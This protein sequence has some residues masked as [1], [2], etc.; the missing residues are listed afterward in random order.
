MPLF[1]KQRNE[2][3]VEWMDREDC[4]VEL[5]NNTYSQFSKINKLLSGWNKIYRSHIRPVIQRSPEKHVTILDIG[6]GGGD[7]IK[8]LDTLIKEDG[9]Q[10]KITG[11]DPDPRSIRFLQDRGHPS[12]LYFRNI[13]SNQL[14]EEGQT[15]NIVISNH[16]IH[17]LSEKELHAVCSDAEILTTG[18]AIFSD[19]ERSDIGY[20]SFGMIAPLL[21]RNSYIVKDG[22]IS[23]R[24]SYRKKEL[25]QI[26]PNGWKV[27][28]A[29]PFRLLATYQPAKT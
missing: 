28:R 27:S 12:N 22:L 24:K 5:L 18:L 4:N 15:F 10:A 7:I 19:I 9:F 29:F 20:A 6:C 17:H 16:L 11:I 3:L 14:T 1:L 13:S 23:V 8:L 26:L 25:Q 2:S 21:F